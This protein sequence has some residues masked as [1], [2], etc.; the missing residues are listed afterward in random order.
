M[1]DMWRVQRPPTGVCPG[2]AHTL[3]AHSPF[4]PFTP[5]PRNTVVS[6]RA[7][8]P[9]E[10][11]RAAEDTGFRQGVQAMRRTLTTTPVGWALVCWM[12][13]GRVPHAPLLV[14]L[15]LF[16]ASWTLSLWSLRAVI[17]GGCDPRQH[18]R[19]V[20][21]AAA[22]DG[23]AWGL[24][25]AL[26]AG[27]D[28]VL[29]AWLGAVLAGV[30]AVNAP[31]YITIPRCF[32]ALLAGMWLAALPAW[33]LQPQQMGVMQTFVG[34]S[35]F[36][37]LL[38]YYMAP[39]AQRVIEGIQLQIA[40]AVLAEQ[41]RNALQ[42]VEQ[43][44]ATDALTGAPNRR[45]LDQVLVREVAL[46]ERSRQPFSLLLLDIDHFKQINDAHGHL[47]GDAALQAFA[48]RVREGL[49]AGDV[50]ARYGGEEFV[51]LLPATAL[52][53][54][55]EI[56]ERLR[57]AMA[58]SAL[59]QAP[60]VRATVSIGAAEFCRGLTSQELLNMADQAVYA[61]KKRGRDRV[62]AWEPVIA[63]AA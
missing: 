27:R 38:G 47:V 21:C 30:A 41:L 56:A 32:R 16:A 52:G 57:Q 36:I 33:L 15:A 11:A 18:G 7:Q 35:V 4:T 34:L 20:K 12:C 54:A 6:A 39:I 29:D 61:A 2:K 28:G 49:R 1:R 63:L 24:V 45:A 8:T 14:W 23:L 19:Q 26:L 3:F 43:E 31:V 40:N 50:C 53:A 9:A 60:E 46:A 10:L 51:V 5:P 25:F 62:C 13:W 48:A 44:A 59:L 37:G 42:L 58:A 17:R 55:L 22:L